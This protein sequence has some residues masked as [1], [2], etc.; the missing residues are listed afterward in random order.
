MKKTCKK[1][2]LVLM[3]LFTLLTVSSCDDDKLISFELQGEETEINIVLDQISPV[4]QQGESFKIGV[5]LPNSFDNQSNV[6]IE[7][8]NPDGN[9][10]TGNLDFDAGN[11]MGVVSVPVPSLTGNVP[12]NGMSSSVFRVKGFVVEGDKPTRYVA[13][14]NSIE[15]PLWQ[16]YPSTSDDISILFDWQKSL[17]IDVDINLFTSDGEATEIGSGTG[18]RFEGFS[19]GGGVPD[20]TYSLRYAVYG[21]EENNIGEDIE[22]KLFVRDSKG[23]LFIFEGVIENINVVSFI[24]ENTLINVTKSTDNSDPIRPVVS[25]S[26]SGG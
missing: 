7:V 14:S 12:F 26:I 11:T 20:D 2:K 19:F 8:Q 10:S 4:A 13:T 15:V 16:G 25:Y 6:T 18:S 1:I 3:S 24:E 17:S 9:A 23:D 5:T 21:V 22:Y